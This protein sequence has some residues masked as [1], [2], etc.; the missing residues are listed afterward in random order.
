MSKIGLVIEGGGFRGLFAEGVTDWLIDNKIE[1]PY[2]IGVSMGASTGIS[3]ITKQKSRNYDIAMTF[4]ED[5]RYISMKNLLTTG[6]LFGMDFIFDD[7][8]NKYKKFDF[9]AFEKSKQECVIGAMN[10]TN[11]QTTYLRKSQENNEAMM[12]ALKAS[13]S[14][15]FVAQV[16]QI[17]NIPHLDGGLNDPIPVKQAFLD[18]CDKVIIILTRDKTYSKSPFK[19]S[20]ISK[21]FYSDYPM[22]VDALRNRHQVYNQTQKIIASLVEDKKAIVIRPRTALPIGRLEKNREKL[23]LVYQT[24]Y[25]QA[26]FQK[27]ELL[28]FIQDTTF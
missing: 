1:L 21:V 13:V 19:A 11:G 18:G 5:S 3:Y 15:P 25:Q 22:V 4:L 10:C 9:E 17:N 2:V 23:K 26:E 7:I 28:N 12:D 24:G 14:L 8:A 20:P 27:E 6:S 16:A